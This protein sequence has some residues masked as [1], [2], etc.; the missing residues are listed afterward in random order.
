MQ[1]LSA[2][3]V[4][5]LHLVDRGSRFNAKNCVRAGQIHTPLRSDEASR[6]IRRKKTEY[7]SDATQRQR[8]GQIADA[9][10]SAEY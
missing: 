10:Q 1:H 9:Q 3:P 2:H 4:A 8:I 6:D 7:I 5:L